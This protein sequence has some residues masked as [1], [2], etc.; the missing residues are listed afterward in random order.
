MR[1]LVVVLLVSATLVGHCASSVPERVRV[2]Q[3]YL[4]IR[5]DHPEPDYAAA[6]AWI[7]GKCEAYGLKVRTMEYVSGKPV[8]L[9]SVEGS[10]PTLPSVVLNS[11][12]DVVT[13][14]DPSLWSS[15]PF[16]AAVKGN[17]LIAR[18]V[19]D[20]KSVGAQ[21]LLAVRD[22]LEEGWQPLRSIHILWVPEEETGGVDGMA[23]F[24]ES[25]EFKDLNVGFAMDEGL[26][27]TGKVFNVYYAERSTWKLRIRVQGEAGHSAT[28]P[29]QTAANRLLEILNRAMSVR[30]DWG[31]LDEPP[32]GG[33][34]VGGEGKA[35]GVNI[36]YIHAGVESPASET[37][38]V[39]NILPPVA[40]AGIDVRVSPFVNEAELMEK[41]NSWV[42]CHGDGCLDVTLE[43]VFR[44]D[45]GAVTSLDE[46]QN[47]FYGSFLRA[48]KNLGLS[49]EEHVFPGG[50]DARYIR[51]KNIPAVGFSPMNG[52]ENQL[53]CADESLDVDIFVRGVDY[54]RTIIR[55][56]A[57]T[58]TAPHKEEL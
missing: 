40:E 7:L 52:T 26:P 13:P 18:G 33:G 19:Q 29:R 14:G 15:G 20:M 46:N 51:R 35:V 9:C 23:K 10:D 6:E 53:H 4:Q 43:V 38:F 55:E 50:T 36:I 1:T 34:M 3:E 56:V 49:T 11:H 45:G 8:V 16:E 42:A 25:Q 5:T 31:R 32:S 30:S 21:Y 54:Y 57:D 44:S 28:L 12:T 41:I 27:R 48:V 47:P 37:G 58:K 2:F 39:M 24:V 17:S 22:L